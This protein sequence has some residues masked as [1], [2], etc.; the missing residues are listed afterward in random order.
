MTQK[1]RFKKT[2]LNSATGIVSQVVIITMKFI[3]RTIFIYTL[4]KAYLGINGLFADILNMLSLTDLG[5]D[6]A[7]NFRLYKP[8]AEGNEKRVRLLLK[9]YR[10]AYKIVGLVIFL[11]GLSLVPFL[12]YLIKDFDSLEQLGVNAVLIFML[13][14]LQS[15][16]S[17]FFFA[18]RSAV[19]RADQCEYILNYIECI[20]TILTNVAQIIILLTTKNFALYTA[21]GILFVFIKN[22]AEAI[23][24]KKIYPSFFVKDRDRIDRDEVN[25]ILKDCGALFVYRVNGVVL[26]ATDN[27]VLSSFIGLSMVGVYSNYL[28]FSVTIQ[29]FLNRIYNACRASLGN[30]FATENIE[31]KYLMF[32]TMNFITVLLYGTSAIVIAL[33]SN[34]LISL[35]IGDDYVISAPFTFLFG[36]ELL[37]IGT[38]VH[39]GQIRNI[40]GAFRQAWYRPL[41]GAGLNIIISVALV[42]QIGIYGVVIGTIV[43]D[44]MT[45]LVVDPV[46]IF[47]QSF[48]GYMSVKQYYKDN[49]V[50]LAVLLT[51]AFIDYEICAH[52]LVNKGIISLISHSIICIVSVPCVFLLLFKNKEYT[53]YIYSKVKGMK[54]LKRFLN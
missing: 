54:I 50:Y 45:V 20:I 9:F 48:C 38:R 4:G 39:L 25:K 21:V 12:K 22:S 30:Y 52:I 32:E 31:K 19:I 15:V 29:N 11:L 8:L 28:L 53:K 26:N 17:Y 40:I 23:T 1:G 16:S 35:W 18:Y 51:V 43:A 42:Q 13:Y 3:T 24:A 6:A 5:I 10:Q 27:L 7:M 47:K 14:L 2:V 36:I 49:I 37:T 33:I 41:V 46:V 34:E 44:A